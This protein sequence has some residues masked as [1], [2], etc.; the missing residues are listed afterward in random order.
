MR[1]TTTILALLATLVAAPAATADESGLSGR[2][3][4]AMGGSGSWSGAYV[5][6]ADSGKPVFAW[7]HTTPRILASNTKL[8]T[9]AAALARFG[10]AGTLATEVRGSGELGS[11]GVYRGN[12]YLVGG[13]DPT[14]G[15]ASFVSRSYGEGATVEALAA[16]LDRAGIERVAG[17]VLGDESAF[18]NL[19]GGPDSGYGVSVWVGPLSALGYNRGLGSETG[20]SFQANPPSFAAARLAD[21]LRRRG[22]AVSGAAGSGTAPGA[23]DVLAAVESPSMARLAALTNKPSDNYFAEMLVKDLALDVRYTAGD[24]PSQSDSQAGRR[25]VTRATTSSGARIAA[26]F[27]KRIGGRPSR[28]ADGSGLSRLNRASP[29]RVVKLLLAMRERD[30]FRA[31]S[32]S[33]SIAGRDGTLGPRM[34]SGPARGHCRGKTGTLSDVSAVS[35][36]CR[37]RS[38]DSYVFSILMNGVDPYGARAIQD[39]MLQA[40]AGVR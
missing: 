2:L 18:D 19:R 31:F 33:L 25:V 10:T 32:R 16:Q 30:E 1:R 39:R 20:S 8:F 23:A 34:R 4:A 17:R 37:A 27:A 28:L 11:R 9:T 21:A 40:L 14:F 5:Y 7:R 6:N 26:R 15:S 38:G 29:Y 12:L 35:G 22:I 36:Y 3:A 24:D 13:G